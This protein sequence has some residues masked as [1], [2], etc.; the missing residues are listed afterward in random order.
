M[1]IYELPGQEQRLVFTHP[2]LRHFYR[3][4]QMST[5]QSEAGGQLF[6]KITP[7]IVIVAAATG[8]HKR[9]FRRRFSFIPNKKRLKREIHDNFTKGLHYVGD[10]HTHP[11][12]NPS[13]SHLDLRS[14]QDVF[15]RSQHELDHFVLV[16]VGK[17]PI[18]KAIWVSTINHIET[19]HLSRKGT[20]SP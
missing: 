19:M 7:R 11:Q 17:E 15:I 14:M 10:W 9:D 5:W 12:K 8:P 2:V 20:D 16:I 6:A 13:P 4:R 3:Y 1:H 18:Q